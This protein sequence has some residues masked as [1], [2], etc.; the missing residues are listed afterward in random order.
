MACRRAWAVLLLAACTDRDFAA[1]QG[2]SS[3]ANDEGEAST[4]DEPAE[5]VVADGSP[6]LDGTYPRCDPARGWEQCAPSVDQQ[7]ITLWHVDGDAA[8]LCGVKE[9]NVCLC[10]ISCFE[11][12]ESHSPDPSVCPIPHSGTAVPVCPGEPNTLK[13]CWL[14]CEHGESCPDGMSCVLQPEFELRVCAWQAE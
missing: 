2:S 8:E 7:V 1:P 10:A 5:D 4:Q 3:R 12:G 9:C 13:S 14:T 11:E 6:A